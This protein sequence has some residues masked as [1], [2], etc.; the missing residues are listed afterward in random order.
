MFM[1]LANTAEHAIGKFKSNSFSC[2]RNFD[3]HC[4][5]LNNCIGEKNYKPFF[6]LIVIVSIFASTYI[7]FAIVFILDFN[8]DAERSLGL[9]VWVLINISCV[10]LLFFL[11]INLVV[12]HLWL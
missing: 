4:K 11:D 10:G 8:F 3:H 12:F 1:E 6:R 2:V 5:W 9:F 7:A